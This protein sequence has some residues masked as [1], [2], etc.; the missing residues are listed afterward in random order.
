VPLLSGDK[1]RGLINLQ[2]LERENAF[3]PSDVRLLQT[4]ANTM[5]VALENA[6]LFDETQRRARETAALAAVGRE[7]SS[8]L[9]LATLMDMIAKNA[10]DLLV[11][12]NSA[13]FLPNGDGTYRAIVAIGAVAEQ[14]RGFVVTEGSGIIG[15]VLKSRRAEFVNDTGQDPRSRHIEG[16]DKME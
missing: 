10:K 15:D 1:A 2:D 4:F 7:I 12:E 3:S 8:T 13:I 9:D 14:I 11:A 5:S 6:R 16:T